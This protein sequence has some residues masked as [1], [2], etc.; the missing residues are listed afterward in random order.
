M[1]GYKDLADT[2]LKVIWNIPEGA[3]WFAYCNYGWSYALSSIIHGWVNNTLRDSPEMRSFTLVFINIMAQSSTAWTGLLA[4]LTVEAHDF[5][6]AIA[7]PSPCR[8]FNRWIKSLSEA[9]KRSEIKSSYRNGQ[10]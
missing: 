6:R 2:I 4:Y 1:I 8:H 7:S 5:R 9:R 3:K 10:L